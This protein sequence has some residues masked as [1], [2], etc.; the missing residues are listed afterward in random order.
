MAASSITLGALIE[1]LGTRGLIA[2]SLLG[3]AL[4][5]LFAQL[6]WRQIGFPIGGWSRAGFSWSAPS[7]WGHAYFVPLISIA[8]IYTRRE[9][10]AQL[11]VRVFWP[12]LS[13]VLLGIVCYAYFVFKFTNH[14]FQGASAIL[15]LGAVVMLVLGPAV[16]RATAFPIA[17]LGLGLTISEM[18]LNPITFQLKLF[19]SLGSHVMLT[20]VGIENELRGNVLEIVTSDGIFP[21]NV[22]EACSGMRMVV[23]FIALSV[24]VAFFSCRQWWQRIMI[25]LLALPVA[26]LMNV[27]RVTVLAALTLVDPGFSVGDAHTFIGTLLLIPALGLFL[28]CVW[29]VRK[30]TPD[31]PEAATGGAAS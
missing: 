26:V 5:A 16:L 15:V 3:A 27:V 23:A 7:D 13:M 14:M 2:G 6:I 10:I 24:V 18:V 4:L 31:E 28:A 17:F 12:A 29:A 8:Y 30:I 1:R 20:L 22:A 21:L 11:P 25:V 9:R 19:A